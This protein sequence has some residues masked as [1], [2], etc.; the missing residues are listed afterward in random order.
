MYNIQNPLIYINNAI[1]SQCTKS[2]PN[3]ILSHYYYFI[4]IL[5]LFFLLHVQLFLFPFLFFQLLLLLHV[6]RPNG[7]YCFSFYCTY[8]GLIFLGLVHCITPHHINI[9]SSSLCFRIS[10]VDHVKHQ[11]G[12]LLF[13]LSLPNLTICAKPKLLHNILFMQS[14][15]SLTW[16]STIQD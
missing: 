9:L 16:I 8:R 11:I 6:Q 2:K 13:L 12:I 15:I 3:I 10:F 5:S 1:Y 4:F 7:L 14:L